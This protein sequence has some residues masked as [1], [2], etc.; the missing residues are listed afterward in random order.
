MKKIFYFIAIAFLTFQTPSKAINNKRNAIIYPTDDEPAVLQLGELI[1]QG[2]NIVEY[3]TTAY[4]LEVSFELNNSLRLANFDIYIKPVITYDYKLYYEANTYG[5]YVVVSNYK[6]RFNYISSFRNMS[7][8]GPNPSWI[9]QPINS[10][11][12]VVANDSTDSYLLLLTNFDYQGEERFEN[13]PNNFNGQNFLDNVNINNDT[14]QISY[15]ISYIYYAQYYNK[16][17]NKYVD[18]VSNRI[19]PYGPGTKQSGNKIMLNSYIRSSYDI[20]NIKKIANIDME[21]FNTK[22]TAI[23]KSSRDILAITQEGFKTA[24]DNGASQEYSKGYSAGYA[25]GT[26][27][28]GEIPWLVS[29]FNAIDNIFKIEIFPGLKIWYIVAIPI[30]F[31]LIAF[32]LSF[33]R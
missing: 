33:F 15:S 25:N 24:Y 30:I 22:N 27:Q 17:D 28:A 7:D 16:N 3:E 20:A 12:N 29:M 26:A 21:A 19:R 2:S 1:G 9:N 18:Y 14:A 13:L 11:V 6:L 32:V 10:F 8:T 4:Q 23:G 31:S 5:T